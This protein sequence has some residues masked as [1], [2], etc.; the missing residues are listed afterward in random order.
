MATNQRDLRE[1]IV[2]RMALSPSSPALREQAADELMRRLRRQA[3]SLPPQTRFKDYYPTGR[4]VPAF[5]REAHPIE[6]LIV[7]AISRTS[8]AA[9]FGVTPQ[10]KVFT[11]DTYGWSYHSG[12]REDV[13]GLSHLLDDAAELY[14]DW[15]IRERDGGRF[16]E[17]DGRF[18]YADDGN[19]FLEAKL[20]FDY[21][22]RIED[23]PGYTEEEL[24]VEVL[25][26]AKH[27]KD[28][29]G[30][31]EAKEEPDEALVTANSKSLATCHIGVAVGQ[32]LSAT[33]DRGMG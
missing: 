25:I 17:R 12:R 19:V 20:D 7:R 2:R 6:L 27:F 21:P 13:T 23:Q 1:E 22:Q 4:A 8:G 14:L 15:K 30:S 5:R 11:T 26:T 28:Q 9:Q 18:F 31:M 33:N 3:C 32:R 24:P 16:Y 29:P 10:G